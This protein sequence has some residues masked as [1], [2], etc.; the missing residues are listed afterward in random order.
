MVIILQYSSNSLGPKLT[1]L[2]KYDLL[3]ID[4]RYDPRKVV[5]AQTKERRAV[6]KLVSGIV[7][8]FDTP[9]T[10]STINMVLMRHEKISSVNRGRYFTKF[11]A[12]MIADRNK[13][14]AVHKPVHAYTGRKGLTNI[15][16]E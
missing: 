8:V 10:A 6:T 1:L 3:R 13:I 16:K 7:K 2:L 12:D 4:L 9:D 5:A 11:D 15:A 14:A